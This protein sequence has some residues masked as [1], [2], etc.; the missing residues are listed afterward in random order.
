MKRAMSLTMGALMAGV[1]L[2]QVG[3][4]SGSNAESMA[5]TG[6]AQRAEDHSVGL[7]SHRTPKGGL[8]YDRS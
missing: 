1:A 4:Q 6:S 8:A 5:L 2:M 7:T 3:C